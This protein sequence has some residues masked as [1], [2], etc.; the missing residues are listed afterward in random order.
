MNYQDYINYEIIN[1]KLMRNLYEIQQKEMRE[2]TQSDKI[3]KT[4]Q[5][6][7]EWKV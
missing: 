6:Y 5:N 1:E 2:K 3:I 4:N 7:N